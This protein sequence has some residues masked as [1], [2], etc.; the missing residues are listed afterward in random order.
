VLSGR[1]RVSTGHVHHNHALLGRR[2][3]IDII[4]ANTGTTTIGRFDLDT[5]ANGR[6]VGEKFKGLVFFIETEA[7]QIAKDT[8]RGKG[9]L[10]I[11]SS[12]VASAL[13]MA[14]V[15]DYTPLI[16]NDGLVVD[17]TGNTFVGIAMKRYRVYVDPYATGNYCVVGFKGSGPMEAGL[18]Y[19][20]YVPL[21]RLTATDPDT[22]QPVVGYKTRYAVAQNPFSLGVINGAVGQMA[23]TVTKDSNVFYRRIM[24]DNLL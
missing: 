12:N 24:I 15:L 9:N 11:C 13:Q 2:G 10:I 1:N 3:Q 21:A 17:D 7:N 18:Y 8:R 4:D 23:A 5:D 19:C 16:N 20:P 22:L 14:G 6:W